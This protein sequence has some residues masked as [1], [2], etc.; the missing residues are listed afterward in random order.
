MGAAIRRPEKGGR[1]AKRE[2]RQHPFRWI[3]NSGRGT[4]ARGGRD[5]PGPERE[6]EGFVEAAENRKRAGEEVGVNFRNEA[7]FAGCWGDKGRKKRQKKKS[8]GMEVGFFAKTMSRD[9]VAGGVQ[10]NG[11][12]EAGE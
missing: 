6:R 2:S 4:P 8:A 11:E 1:K 12:G 3:R 9:R 10:V 5:E 7:V